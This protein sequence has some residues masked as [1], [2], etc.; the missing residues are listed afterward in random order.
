MN[1]SGLTV[2]FDIFRHLLVIV[3]AIYCVS[4]IWNWNWIVALIAAVPVY[5]VVLNVI[6][7]LTLPLYAFTPE[8]KLK[9]QGW[10]AIE[11]GNFDELRR[12]NKEMEGDR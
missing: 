9:R 5:I 7:F 2:V 10:K 12:V 3:I 1:K 8:N 6:G 4:L 11:D